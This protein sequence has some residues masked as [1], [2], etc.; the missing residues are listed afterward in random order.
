MDDLRRDLADARPDNLPSLVRLRRTME[1]RGIGG[2]PP[3]R[4]SYRRL[5]E[6]AAT[7]F[8][9]G[10]HGGLRSAVSYIDAA[11]RLVW[12]TDGVP[13]HAID[14][15]D[16]CCG[17]VHR[18]QVALAEASQRGGLVALVY[19]DGPECQRMVDP[20]DLPATVVAEGLSQ[21]GERDEDGRHTGI[22][23]RA[24]VA[25]VDPDV[26]DFP[27]HHWTYTVGVQAV[28]ETPDELV[29]G[30]A[31]TGMAQALVDYYRQAGAHRVDHYE[32][33]ALVRLCELWGLEAPT[34]ARQR[35]EDGAGVERT[36]QPLTTSPGRPN[37][38]VVRF[39]D[40]ST[41]EG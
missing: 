8:R 18:A 7:E 10:T 23:W 27:H 22:P 11:T 39:R 41:C 35:V 16:A 20:G 6:R 36:S 2:E 24:W 17:V 15:C 21:L 38:A 33:E 14:W 19:I 3:W 4:E 32:S 12:A 25:H 9:R 5:M 31:D 28:D 34:W 30:W 1:R 26:A 13:V 40:G 37:G 29:A